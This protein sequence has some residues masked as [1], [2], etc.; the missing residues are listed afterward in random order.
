LIGQTVSHYRIVKKLGGGGM[1]VVYEAE[2]TRLGRRVAL[3]FLPE[4]LCSDA[5][6]LDR[7]RREARAAS[8]L[9]HPN[10][11]TIYDIEEHE[12]RPFI[13]MELLEGES[14]K[15]R[16]QR[17]PLDLEH[18]LTIGIQ[19]AEALQAA[20]EQGIIHRDIKPGN[21]FVNQRGQAKILDF[22]LA[23]LTPVSRLV[24]QPAGT[25]SM[26][27]EERSALTGFD[28]IPGTAF[29]MSPEQI[30]REE[31]DARSDLFS[32]GV[33]LYEMATG[34]KPFQANNSV[35][36]LAAIL[37]AKPVSPLTLRPSLPDAMETIVG[38]ALE[39]DR[40]LRY[41]NASELRAD[42]KKLEFVSDTDLAH[43]A[44][45][46]IARPSQVFRRVSARTTYVLLGVAGVLIMLLVVFTL[47][48]VK[49]GRSGAPSAAKRGSVA[50]LPFQNMSED[51]TTEFLRVALADEIAT[52]LTYMPS[53]EIRP[54]TASRR[55][56]NTT[57]PQQ[58]GR[59]L[60]V[61]TV[62]TGH[63]V[64]QGEKLIIT[65]EAVD[66]QSNRLAWQ[67]TITVPA[68][69]LIG[70]QRQI[71]IQVRQGLLPVLGGAS[72]AIET[73]TR[74]KN[75]DAY[76][77][78]LRAA[79]VAHDPEPNREAIPML[80]RSVA[81]D[82]TY[83]PAWDALG[84][85]YYYD[86]QYGGGGRPAFD[87]AV[88]AYARA[89]ALDPNFVA[90][91]GHLARA[92]VERGDL[93]DGHR[94]AEEL[95][96]RRPDNAQAHFTRAYVLRYAGLLEE[97]MREC[98]IA[99][100]LDPGNYFF[101]S[102]AFAFFQAGRADRA[103]EYISLDAGSEWF[104]NLTPAILLRQGKIQDARD[105]AGRMTND[106]TWF[107]SLLQA[108]LGRSPALE[109]L[110][111]QAEP[112]LLGQR[113][114]EF[115]YHQGAIMAYCG[116]HDLALRLLKSA[117][118]QNYCST[119]ALQLDPLLAPLRAAPEFAELKSAAQNCQHQVTRK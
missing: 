64:R 113:D 72:G 75:S 19:L 12:G 60:R 37:E 98:D 79:A 58:V 49:H 117:I 57:D 53:L 88:A 20:H 45:P 62:V 89:V 28:I 104:I 97:A 109:R 39:K 9:N 102:C 68:Q 46:L 73:A 111:R 32:L 15:E 94:Q 30:R 7:F 47:W 105:S 82:P 86:S 38:K 69:D 5:N 100:G 34:R 103:M 31:L 80:E 76:D 18:V 41:Q 110:V 71:G 107:G 51:P 118:Q 42:L 40:A 119:A 67:G 16:L 63:Y 92:S 50:V 96:R 93:T 55:F 56:A 3:K 27:E 4:E 87:R 116:Q 10:I 106:R 23:K 54:M 29:Y 115:R 17:G 14:L 112:A 33:V 1:G 90:A 61:G 78:Y 13:V 91:V 6:A 99:L 108:C 83:A 70:M 43:R 81:L 65:L 101:R 59:A 26:S 22:G 24:A 84:L 52:A 114:P 95:L 74:P 25:A 21:V 8:S 44:H 48:W 36:T 85:R 66:V 11:C 2:D 77:Y 35:L